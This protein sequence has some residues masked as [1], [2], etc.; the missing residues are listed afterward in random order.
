[1]VAPLSRRPMLSK[2]LNSTKMS[3]LD[4]NSPSFWIL[5]ISSERLVGITNFQVIL[6]FEFNSVFFSFINLTHESKFLS[7]QMQG[8]PSF[9]STRTPREP[10]ES[11]FS[12][13]FLFSA[14]PRMNTL[15][16]TTRQGLGASAISRH[17]H[18]IS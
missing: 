17:I 18:T 7:S 6:S 3:S 8:R 15:V 13:E 5:L 9:C 11:F 16:M 12:L 2:A 14:T 10:K 4:L 1:V